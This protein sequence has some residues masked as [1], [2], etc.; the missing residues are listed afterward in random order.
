MKCY[1]SS[2]KNAMKAIVGLAAAMVMSGVSVADEAAERILAGTRYASTLQHQ[3]LHGQMLKEGKSTPVSLFLRGEDI[4]F[5]YKVAGQDKRF[6]MRLKDDHFDLLEIVKGVTTRFSDEKLAQRINGTDLSYE[7]LAMRFLYWK[8]STVVGK[9]KVN[10][11]MCFKLRLQ[12]PSKT[13]GDYRI[14]YV[15]VHE[16]YGAMM[17]VVGYNAQG[18]PLK[19]FQVTDLMRVGKEYTLEKMRVDSIDPA[20]NKVV[21]ITYLEFERPSK[22]GSGD[23][24]LR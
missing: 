10:G 8:D 17:K 11:Q 12:N 16:K 3:N 9:E 23:K 13:A 5:L 21:G 7:D 19:Q 15:W 20:S 1:F 6:H 18:R 22:V 14:V 2:M 24:P 4:Q